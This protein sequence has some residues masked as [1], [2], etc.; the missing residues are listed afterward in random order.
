MT[1]VLSAAAL[2]PILLGVVWFLPPLATLVLAE[3][4]LVAAFI[5]YADLTSR[6]DVPVPRM[7]TAAAV[8]GTCAV[9]GVAP[10]MVL[11]I[12]IAGTVGVAVVQLTRWPQQSTL[13]AVSAATFAMLYLGVPIGSMVAL[14]VS[15]GREI[16]L[17]LL[18]TVMVSDTAQYY[19]GRL[20]GR[21]P[22]APV[23]SPKKTVEGALCGFAAGTLLLWGAGHWWLPDIAG[24]GRVV[25]GATIVALGIASDLFESTLKRNAS[26]KDASH[27]IPGHGGVLDR[28]DALL[29]A[30][31]IFY[32]VVRLAN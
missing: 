24:G 26:V 16:L 15:H 2:L 8:L 13:G 19:G 10:S 31:P 12:I 28:L 6:L 18:G 5:E 7:L 9:V 25:L 30:A 29:F 11:V 3:L 32:S 17:L 23:I 27:I 22:L 4:V 21:R 1:R 14:R 20:F